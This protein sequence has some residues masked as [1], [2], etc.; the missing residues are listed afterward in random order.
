M[1]CLNMF[2]FIYFFFTAATCVGL[3]FTNIASY[4]SSHPLWVS[5]GDFNNDSQLDIAVANSGGG[6]VGILLGRGNGTFTGPTTFS[7]DSTPNSVA[8]GDFNND[9]RLDIV[10]A[11]YDSASVGILLGSGNGT[12]A[13]PGTFST[14]S[15]SLA[16]GDVNNDNLLD[17]IVANSGSNNVSILLGYG[18][19]FFAAQRVLSTGSGSNPFSVAVGDFNQDSHLDI[20]VANHLTSN[21]GILLG[22]GDGTF[23]PQATYSTGSSSDPTSI[24][25]GDFNQDN[26]LDIA[27]VNGLFST[28]GILL[29]NGDGT[30]AGVAT[31]LTSTWSTSV[32]VADINGDTLLDIIVAQTGAG[33]L[34]ILL[35]YGNGTFATQA[36]ISVG[37]TP[38]AVAIGDFNSDNRLDIAV[39]NSGN[40]LVDIWLRAC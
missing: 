33:N 20:A 2:C 7:T 18:N 10:V 22:F 14:G 23:A 5:L 24:S 9:G 19:G 28:S 27:V 34:G 38:Y 3:D 1:K 11:N 4:S 40:D 25:V 13:G 35:G 37:G 36:N 39:A 26:R 31:L 29:G 16:V 12:F 6:N 30:L 21:V 15:N 8:V 32:A 17:I